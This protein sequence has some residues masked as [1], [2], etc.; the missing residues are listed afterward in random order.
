MSGIM[1]KIEWD[2]VS[3]LQQAF[4][5]V[6]K[7]GLENLT[8]GDYWLAYKIKNNNIDDEDE[9]DDEEIILYD[10][11][12]ENTYCEDCI[13]QEIVELQAAFVNGEIPKPDDYGGEV[14]YYYGGCFYEIDDFI[15]C[16]RCEKDIS[17][18]ILWYDDLLNWFLKDDDEGWLNIFRE[19][20]RIYLCKLML[21]LERGNG[22][23]DKLPDETIKIAEK[24][25]YFSTKVANERN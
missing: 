15:E 9:E 24:V 10:E 23:Y 16:N 18:S 5:I 19:K 7:E 12:S 14:C 25:I 17:N 2:D 13:E 4:D 20:D 1:S 22:S 21:I 8:Y 3:I 11:E 6:E